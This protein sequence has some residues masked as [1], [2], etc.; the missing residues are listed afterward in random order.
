MHNIATVIK[1]V[2]EAKKIYYK[3]TTYR[4]L[5]ILPKNMSTWD[6]MSTGECYCSTTGPVC[7]VTYT[8]VGKAV[9]ATSVSNQCQR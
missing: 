9:P 4:H 7:L 8:N 5:S 2:S 3:N 6:A 1:Q